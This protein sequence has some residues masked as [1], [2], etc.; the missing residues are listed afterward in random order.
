MKFAAPENA[1]YVATIV[2]VRSLT[3]LDG[4]DNL[5][6]FYQFG[7]QALVPKDTPID[8][9]GVLFTAESQ[10]SLDYAYNNNLHRHADLNIDESQTGYLEDSRR[11]KAI[12]LRGHRS[13]ALFMPLESLRYLGVKAEDFHEGDVFDKIGDHEIVRKYY[14]K[15]PQ[16]ARK[17]D[18]N[19]IPKFRR[20]D[21]RHFPLH[22]DTENYFRNAN[23]IPQDAPIVVTQKL[24]GTSVRIANTLVK[25]KL[26]WLERLAKR[27]G[28]KV[29]EEEY[30]H[31]YG[32]R[33][34]TKDVNNPD[35]NHYYVSDVWTI[36][37]KEIDDLIPENYIVYG[38]LIGWTPEGAELQ[39]NYTYN[40]P[41]GEAH[42]YIYRVAVVTHQGF[43]V[44]LSW[45][46]VRHFAEDR[47]L[48]TVPELWRGQHSEFRAEDWMDARFEEV[49][50]PAVPLSAPKTF[51]EG[52]CIRT[53]IGR[54]PYILKAKS[55]KFLEH[56]TKMLDEEAF[57][58]EAEEADFE[59]SDGVVFG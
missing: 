6:G 46:Q 40:V 56:E 54:A 17:I 48:R 53:D 34:V 58:A 27:V 36:A 25:R 30:D 1:N 14:I 16:N 5:K 4:L 52:V 11:V 57:D 59:V 51:D 29:A 35:Q 31:V 23:A 38:E 10:L 7:Y 20:V 28:V 22:F 9:L 26:N 47:G 49:D 19:A 3:D 32:S 24:H 8:S 15:Q 42:L 2:R 13:D 21:E 37:G 39:K 43:T 44:D 41:Q 50:L 12:K 33:K 45:D 18:K 55:P